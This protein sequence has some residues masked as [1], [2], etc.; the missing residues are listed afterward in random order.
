MKKVLLEIVALLEKQSIAIS[1]LEAQCLP[2]SADPAGSAQNAP[3]SGAGDSF[4]ALRARIRA[5]PLGE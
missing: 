2:K 1:G 3:A 4:A 5:M